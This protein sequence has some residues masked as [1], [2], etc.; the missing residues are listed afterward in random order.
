MAEP[1]TIDNDS[2]ID[3][4]AN[5]LWLKAKPNDPLNFIIKQNLKKDIDFILTHKWICELFWTFY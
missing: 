4:E 2:L 1:G 5:I 3:S